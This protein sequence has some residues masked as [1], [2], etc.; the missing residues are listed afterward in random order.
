MLHKTSNLLDEAEKLLSPSEM[1]V[2][3]PRQEDSNLLDGLNNQ[4][5]SGQQREL[6]S[7]EMDEEMMEEYPNEPVQMGWKIS[8]DNDGKPTSTLNDSEAAESSSTEISQQ[9]IN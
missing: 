1:D 8:G 6:D 4:D 2:E 7:D 9:N 5:A 3:S